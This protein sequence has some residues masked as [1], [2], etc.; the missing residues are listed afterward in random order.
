VSAQ[1][2]VINYILKGMVAYPGSEDASARHLLRSFH[3]VPLR[4]QLKPTAVAGDLVGVHL[5]REA[6]QARAAQQLVHVPAM[7]ENSTV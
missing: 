3:Q 4:Q 1:G 7:G 2:H 5:Q 6:V